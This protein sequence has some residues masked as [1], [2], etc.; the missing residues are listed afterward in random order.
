MM[1]ISFAGTVAVTTRWLL[2]VGPTCG[3]PLL[4][5]RKHTPALHARKEKATQAAKHYHADRKV[6]EQ[7]ETVV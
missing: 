2:P 6:R 3:T 7:T 4:N 5:E 1:A